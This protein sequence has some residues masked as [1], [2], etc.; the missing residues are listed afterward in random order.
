PESLDPRTLRLL[1]GQ[2]ELEIQA[3]RW[4]IQNG[5]DARHCHILQ[6]VAGC[7]PERSPRSQ[8]KLLQ[9]QVQKLTQELQEQK[10]KAQLE[11]ECLEERLLQTIHVLQQLETEL[12]AFQ[13]SCLLQLARSS[14]VGRIL[15]SQTGSVEVVTAETLMDPSDSSENDQA[16]AAKEGFRLEDVDWNSIAHRYPNLFT[17]L[18]SNSEQ[19]Q[20]WPT[21]L[22]MPSWES[23]RQRVEGS[24]KSVEWSSLPCVGTS[25]SGGVDSK[26]D[27]SGHHLAVHS[28]VQKVTGHPPRERHC[29]SE[30]MEAQARS[31]SGDWSSGTEGGILENSAQTGRARPTW[32]L[33]PAQTLS[34]GVPRTG[35]GEGTG[36]SG[37]PGRAREGGRRAHLRTA[38]PP[39][40]SLQI[41][42]VSRRDKFVRVANRSREQ[43]ADLSGFVLQQRVRG[44]PVCAFRF[45]P[46]SLLAP[47]HHVTVWGEGPSGAEQRPR[48]TLLL[49]PQG[50]VLSEH[51]PP[52]RVTPV[53]SVFADLTDV[54]ID[55]FPLSEAGRDADAAEQPRRP[56]PPRKGRVR[57]ARAGRRRPRTRSIL[58]PL[59]SGKRPQ[60]REA[61]APP[62]GT[63]TQTPAPLPALP[64]ERGRTAGLSPSSLSC[65]A[66]GKERRV[67]V[68][69]R[70]VDRSCPMV[71][72]SVQSAAESRFGFRF[73][74]CPPRTTDARR[75]T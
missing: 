23:H 61:S 35:S 62:E 44:F 2:R 66:A 43:T 53:S 30:Q 5:Q 46:G 70:S 37:T 41:V 17:N 28:Q 4:A 31:F 3:L 20:P 21:T 27:S 33:S 15:R 45:P 52:H 25:S 74:S 40:P 11:K 69:R 60:P 22:D 42:A 14:W 12:Q 6:E 8:E 26:S 1:W 39:R 58:P 49:S 19:K 72:L 68:C 9:K 55:R 13:K 10:E 73:F 57:E 34:T 24:H 48:V 50:E 32:R 56:R 16:P 38:A 59:S 63:E 36:G 18:E 54:S 47:R 29:A 71:A 64:G 67:R 65:A 7:L 75:T 51:R